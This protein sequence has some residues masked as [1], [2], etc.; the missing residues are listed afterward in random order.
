MSIRSVQAH[1][2]IDYYPPHAPGTRERQ[3]IALWARPQRYRVELSSFSVEKTGAARLQRRYIATFDGASSYCYELPSKTFREARA[4]RERV[5]PQT[6]MVRRQMDYQGEALEALS[7]LDLDHL[8]ALA[9]TRESSVRSQI[10]KYR[11]KVVGYEQIGGV[12]CLRV[13]CRME[14]CGGGQKLSLERSFWLAPGRGWLLMKDQGFFDPCPGTVP[15]HRQWVPR[16]THLAKE[17]AP[18]VWMPIHR[19]LETV[20]VSLPGGRARRHLMFD[21]KVNSIKVN[22]DIPETVFGPPW[23]YG[24]VVSDLPSQ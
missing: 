16:V 22:V 10:E 5:D 15:R 11:G 8:L 12:R 21:W 1:L 19:T 17:A 7:R 4:L 14:T 9:Y 18:G 20:G 13:S 6:W 23:P 24:T 2:V 3:S